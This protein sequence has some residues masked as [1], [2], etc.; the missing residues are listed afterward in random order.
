MSHAR[1][2][3]TAIVFMVALALHGADHLRRGADVVTAQVRAAGAVQFLLGAVTVVLV[4]RRHP[5][6]PAAAIA[7][8]FS[9]AVGFTAAHLLPHWSAFSDPFT[10]ST[11]A[12]GVNVLSWLATV[13]EIAA[14]VALGAAGVAAYR[15]LDDSRARR[16]RIA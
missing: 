5:F 3:R 9:S 6:A 13:V 4:L 8:G 11:V 14:D 1:F 2:R 10:G 15:A 16:G 7:V 12:P